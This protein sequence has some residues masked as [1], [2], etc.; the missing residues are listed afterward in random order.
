MAQAA[1][2]VAHSHRNPSQE[3]S[4]GDRQ[5]SGSLLSHHRHTHHCWHVCSRAACTCSRTQSQGRVVAVSVARVE[6]CVAH[7]RHSRCL[8]GNLVRPSSGSQARHQY[9]HRCCLDRPQSCLYKH[10]CT[11]HRAGKKVVPVAACAD[12]SRHNRSQVSSSCPCLCS[13]FQSR[14]RCIHRSC[15]YP[16]HSMNIYSRTLHW[17]GMR[18]MA[19]ASRAVRSRRAPCV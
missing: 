7:S 13:N 12:R 15:S 16:A 1:A 18:A 5:Q 6:A 17:A 3:G 2:R 10:Y 9:K 14:R 4:P 11:L 8:V 19:V